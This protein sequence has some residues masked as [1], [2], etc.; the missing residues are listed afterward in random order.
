MISKKS[1]NCCLALK[2]NKLLILELDTKCKNA[3]FV[4]PNVFTQSIE[5]FVRFNE[6][7]YKNIAT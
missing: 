2:A 7:M 4:S 5:I 3:A 1:A 6:K